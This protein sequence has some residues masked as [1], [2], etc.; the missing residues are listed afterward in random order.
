MKNRRF[1]PDNIDIDIPDLAQALPIL[2]YG[3]Y[4]VG[5]PKF[6]I[7]DLVVCEDAL[8]WGDEC[9]HDMTL[10]PSYVFYDELDDLDGSA[11]LP[12]LSVFTVDEILVERS[13]AQ[14]VTE[15]E[16]LGNFDF[17][18]DE[19]F[20][21][22]L[23]YSFED[24]IALY[25]DAVTELA[26]HLGVSVEYLKVNLS[27]APQAERK[28]IY[29]NGE[30]HLLRLIQQQNFRTVFKGT[31]FNTVFL[32]GHY[33]DSWSV[34]IHTLPQYPLNTLN[35]T[36]MFDHRYFV[37]DEQD[38]QHKLG[39]E[40]AI[41]L[42]PPG[43]AQRADQNIFG[44]EILPWKDPATLPKIFM[45]RGGFFTVEINLND[46]IVTLI[47]AAHLE[48]DYLTNT[49]HVSDFTEREDFASYFQ[50]EQPVQ[51]EGLIRPKP[52]FVVSCP[53]SS[54]EIKAFEDWFKQHDSGWLQN[55]VALTSET[56]TI[57][58][59]K[60]VDYDLIQSFTSFISTLSDFEVQNIPGL[61]QAAS[62]FIGLGNRSHLETALDEHLST[63]P[64]RYISLLDLHQ[65]AQAVSILIFP[66]FLDLVIEDR[67]HTT[68]F[69][70]F[71]AL[72]KTHQFPFS[73]VQTA[74]L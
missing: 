6:C 74:P 68:D 66:I 31:Q 41:H 13:F 23:R 54:P 8:W 14:E 62:Y 17:E 63:Y 44:L 29:Y 19:L 37:R 69:N 65:D 34:L 36:I 1:Y 73:V 9:E 20:F 58:L 33:S 45:H 28:A 51:A 40:V 38:Q 71:L 22:R 24:S 7:G 70:P 12:V 56:A 15:L 52:L 72:S 60:I 49:F 55:Y 4:Q 59:V 46:R 18:D 43:F 42:A 50:V 11:Y 2:K 61:L 48:I 3:D 57:W 35:L 64:T 16:A 10:D 30:G 53:S 39:P 27:S 32:E 25:P 67:D 26:E 21:Y 5:A 47:Q